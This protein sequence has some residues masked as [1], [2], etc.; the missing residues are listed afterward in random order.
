MFSSP[1]PWGQLFIKKYVYILDS[2]LLYFF[3]G[4]SIFAKWLI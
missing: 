3:H 1:F 4:E 2:L